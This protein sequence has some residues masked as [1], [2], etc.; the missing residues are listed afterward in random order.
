VRYTENEFTKSARE[1]LGIDGGNPH[2]ELWFCGLEYGGSNDAPTAYDPDQQFS[3][4]NI[5]CWNDKR[6]T[7]E[8]LI[9][10][11]FTYDKHCSKVATAYQGLAHEK[12]EDYYIS[13]LYNS[14]GHTFKMN[15]YPLPF[16]RVNSDWNE[17]QIRLTGFKEKSEYR[18]WCR[19]YR[20]RRLRELLLKYKP[21]VLICT[22]INHAK[23]FKDAFLDDPESMP[24]DMKS[25]KR[26][27]K[28]L[29]TYKANESTHLIISRFFGNGQ[30]KNEEFFELGRYARSLNF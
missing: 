20:F 19:E 18:H 17:G 12:Y 25:N 21:R 5:P 10:H 9:Y 23:E 27:Y 29:E 30:M 4:D 13:D 22:G 15:L 11:N 8:P 26:G 2:G 16:P 3:K 7:I 14:G 28:L 1:W 6:K 24:Y